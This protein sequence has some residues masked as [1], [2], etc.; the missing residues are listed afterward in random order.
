MDINTYILGLEIDYLATVTH[1]IEE[2]NVRF[3][4]RNDN[5][6][7]IE[8]GKVCYYENSH[9]EEAKFEEKTVKLWAEIFNSV[10]GDIERDCHIGPNEQIHL[11]EVFGRIELRDGSDN[12]ISSHDL[13]FQYNT[14]SFKH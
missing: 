10:K 1:S 7:D 3:Y 13:E 2:A 9:V 4:I 5:Y 6:P 8:I 12:L 11:S 14:Y